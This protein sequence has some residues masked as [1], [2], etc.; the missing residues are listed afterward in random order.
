MVVKFNLFHKN[1]QSWR[2]MSLWHWHPGANRG[3]RAVSTGCAVPVSWQKGGTVIGRGGWVIRLPQWYC[4]ISSPCQQAP[5]VCHHA[6]WC[7]SWPT[8]EGKKTHLQDTETQALLQLKP[9]L[10]TC[11]ALAWSPHVFGIRPTRLESVGKNKGNC[12]EK[13]V[14]IKQT[15]A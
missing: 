11:E 13:T 1:G 7:G 4:I 15:I 14:C 5:A 12:K 8:H 3:E 2:A 6:A 10:M 9:L